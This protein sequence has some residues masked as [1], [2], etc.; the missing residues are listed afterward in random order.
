V[1]F[2]GV[3]LLLAVAGV[4]VVSGLRTN[5][6]PSAQEVE[7]DQSL[8]SRLIT[9][10]RPW[11][12]GYAGGPVRALF[13]VNPGPYT[14]EW[15]APDTRLREVVELGQRLDLQA[16]AILFGGSSGDEFYGL[17]LGQ[18]RAERLLGVPYHV[19][20]FANARFDKLP[21]R[22]QFLIMEQVARGA[23]LVCCGPTASEYM[24]P[25]RQLAAPVPWLMDGLPDLDGKAPAEVMR[26][27]RLG[28]GR[29]VA[30]DY[31]PWALTPQAE[32]SYGA[33]AE[34]DYRLLWVVRCLLWAASR[35]GAVSVSFRAWLQGGSLPQRP[36]W[37][38]EVARG[39]A[40]PARLQV[41]VNVRRRSDGWTLALDEEGLW[42]YTEHPATL[43]VNLPH[44]RAGA[45]ILDTIVR[46]RRGVEAFAATPFEIESPFG[47]EALVLTQPFA[48]RGGRLA[49]S[50][51]LRGAVPPGTRLRIRFRDAFD[52]VLHQLDLPAPVAENARVPFDYVP[53]A[54]DTVLMRCEAGVL[55]EEQEVDARESTFTVPN[56]RRG[57]FNFLQW[58][59]PT[60]VLAIYA[61]QQLRR[62]GMG[63]CLLSSFEQTKPVPALGAS[64]I[65]L[66]PYVTRILDPKDAQG[67]MQVRQED[68]SNTTLCWNDEPAIDDYVRRLVGHQQKRREHG[69]F[70]YSLGDEGVTQGCCV[71][72]KCLE[73][74][75]R[76]LEGQ[77][78][79]I[80]QL[81]AS[82]GAS[83]A[84]FGEVDLLDR[85]DN[86]EE[87]AKAKGQYAR[88]FDRQAF[89]RWNLMQ[90][91]GRFG[92]AFKGLD[93][94][95]VTGFEGTGGF[96]DD[97]DAI[98]GINGFYSPYPGIGDEIIRSA[99]PRELIRANWMGY[100]KTADAL[101]DAAW[102]MV[103]RNMDSI[104]FWMWTGIGSYRGYLSPTLD[105][106]PATAEL[107]EELRPV[108][109]G[110][111][112][113][114][115]QSQPLHSGIAVFYSLPSALAHGLDEGAGYVGPEATHQTWT[116][117]TS[118]LGL[119][120]RYVTQAMLRRG[121]L[122]PDE[123]RVLLLP[124][125]Q[126]VS[127][128]E[129]QAILS[130][131]EA[132]GTVVADVR[133]GLFDAHCKPVDP[134]TLDGLFGV[135]RTRRAAPLLKPLAVRARIGS[136]EVALQTPLSRLDPGIEA[137]NAKACG[138]V[139]AVPVLLMNAVGR[140]RA[141]LL[142][143]QLLS[144]NAD[145][146]Q[147]AA[148]RAFLRGLYDGVR[149]TAPVAVTSPQD[150]PLPFTE[151]RLWRT[152]DALVIGLWRQMQCAWFAPASGTAA[153]EPVPARLALPEPR[154][155]Y[156]LR[157][158]KFLGRV[159]EVDTLLRWGRANFFL[160]LPER[161]GDLEV[162]LSPTEPRPGDTI[163]AEF[164][165]MGA[166]R[167]GGR[168]AVFAEVLDP[169]GQPVEWAGQVVVLVDGRGS[170]AV[171]VAHNADPG[172]WRLRVT[173]L[174]SREAAEAVWTVR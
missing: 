168:Q 125:A 135:R 63:L 116:R 39:E 34:Y 118:E 164:E 38:I 26:A 79:S 70:C 3:R 62:A 19:Y 134:G 140:G 143:F 20:V 150:E 103:M 43:P 81:N 1:S 137:V 53:G 96:G 64:D 29:G 74:Y 60:D 149:A 101:S 51:A 121:A 94:E 145:E 87:S 112:D 154:Y 127:P 72:P 132:G 128:E 66:V 99:A 4:L 100:S 109:R 130:Y 56:R 167:S 10:H 13:I 163:R 18:Q 102:R 17:G 75:R 31:S 32:F 33:L 174:F 83:Y 138:K 40:A 151:T 52:R 147:W 71:H 142:N 93:P 111:G 114:L 37:V 120:Y 171:P 131:V 80:G 133:P 14:G 2:D 16:D 91:A 7:E 95:A 152:G 119:D 157:R 77:Y 22:F 108:R 146:G 104:W 113:L 92:G 76:Y 88:W 123:F 61:W 86:L 6:V 46:S 159:S 12:T 24:T 106:F 47:I 54:H 115:L 28:A 50:V 124:M 110:L 36:A 44:L 141:I 69:V 98:L 162:Q 30:L 122:R 58:D 35:E 8:S 55:F 5:A 65:S 97:F 89:A 155:I 42:V 82:W 107:T 90:F 59:T 57:Q 68:G 161:F 27:F 67:V 15:F 45:Y 78:G 172:R 49:G 11:A 169:S 144:D 9:P 156:D 170:I 166:G 126:A 21:A 158:G 129:A 160:A 23:G 148:A 117:L 165:L 173:E 136:E 139:E 84:T 73:A 25:A 41:D 153:G 105:F 48:E 85:K